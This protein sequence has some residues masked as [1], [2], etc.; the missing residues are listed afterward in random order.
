MIGDISR[1]GAL[2]SGIESVIRVLLNHPSDNDI[3]AFL[4]KSRFVL[5]TFETIEG[6]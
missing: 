5:V 3:F 4:V 2:Q 1:T 6:L